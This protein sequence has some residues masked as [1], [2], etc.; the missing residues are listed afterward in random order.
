MYDCD[1]TKKKGAVRFS[2]QP[3][4]QAKNVSLAG[5]FSGW[6]PVR[7][8]KQADGSFV[9]SIPG[10]SGKFQYKFVVDGQWI[11]DPD[12]AN[13]VSDSYGGLNSVGQAQ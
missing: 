1:R 6:Q 8:R 12:H 11:H 9:A 7:M 10:V 13:R 5:D 4:N 2:I 3:S